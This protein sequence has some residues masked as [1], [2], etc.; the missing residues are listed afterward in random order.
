MC[1]RFA[2]DVA[3]EVVSE[4]FGLSEIPTIR[5]R[6]NVA[7]TQE[8]GVVRE[9]ADGRNRLDLLHWGL[10]PAWAKE[11]SIAYKMINA[12][13]ETLQE[14]PSFRQAYKYR[15]CVVP[16]SGFYEWRHE[17]K[18]KLPHFIRIRDGHP[19]LFA[20]LW[21]NWKLPEG[22][23]VESFTILTTS[24]NKLLESIHE[25]MPVILHPAECGRWLDRSITNP[26]GLATL[27]QPYPADLLEMWQVSPLVNTVKHDSYEL[28]API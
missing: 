6:Y 28:I 3:P 4:I 10:I 8:V 15:R 2:A 7:P 26:S 1:G 12:R 9:G 27:F 18:A 17:G 11:R 13:S 5:P 22:E 20:G 23:V 24:A 14:K 25:R 19:M 21:E 16:V